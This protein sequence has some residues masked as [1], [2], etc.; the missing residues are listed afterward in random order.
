[1]GFKDEDTKKIKTK[2][3]K[4][5]DKYSEV[6][7]NLLTEYG[8][9]PETFD[10]LPNETHYQYKQRLGRL[11]WR[12]WDCSNCPEYVERLKTQSQKLNEITKRQAE[13]RAE[14]GKLQ[15]EEG[16]IDSEKLKNLAQEEF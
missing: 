10:E 15:R 8:E 1:M 9:L 2:E 4:L 12:K 16:L 7:Y 5:E 11:L 13:I 3:Q 6:R 14:T